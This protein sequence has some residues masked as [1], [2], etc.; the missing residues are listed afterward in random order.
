[1]QIGLFR[2]PFRRLLRQR[3]VWTIRARILL[4]RVKRGQYILHV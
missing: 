1:M 2:V 4:Y 3:Y